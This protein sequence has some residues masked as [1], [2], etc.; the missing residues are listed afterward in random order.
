MNLA[1]GAE[2][3][4]NQGW[5]LEIELSCTRLDDPTTPVEDGWSVLAALERHGYRYILARE[6][7]G[8]GVHPFLTQREREILGRAA[9]GHHNKLIAHDLGIAHSTV[10]VLLAR[11]ASK[12]G[13]RTREEAVRMWR[14][15]DRSLR[16]PP[17]ITPGHSPGRAGPP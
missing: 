9:L 4:R 3:T 11:A 2:D 1:V 5:R 10:R 17:W 12:L 6:F 15:A 7:M 13:V 8:P 16:I 14:L